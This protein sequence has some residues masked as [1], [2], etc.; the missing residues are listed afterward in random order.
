MPGRPFALNP[1]P[2][3]AAV[4]KPAKMIFGA[5][6]QHA[7]ARGVSQPGGF[8]NVPLLAVT[9]RPFGCMYVVVKLVELSVVH[10]LHVLLRASRPK[11]VDESSVKSPFTSTLGSIHAPL[12]G[13]VVADPA[14]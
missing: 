4:V 9:T 10:A 13:T 3:F 6:L 2:V 5:P 12:A 11:L 7:S 8:G 1:P 14:S